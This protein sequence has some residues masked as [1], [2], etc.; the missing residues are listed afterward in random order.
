M[1]NSAT[2]WTILAIA[3]FPVLLAMGLLCVVVPGLNLALVP[4]WT[5]VAMSYVGGFSNQIARCRRLAQRAPDPL[6]N[7]P[8]VIAVQ[9]VN[10]L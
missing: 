7:A 4:L 6:R 1:T 5:L 10:A 8:G 2:F 9:R 3:I